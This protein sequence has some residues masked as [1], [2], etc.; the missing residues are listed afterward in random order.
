MR[1]LDRDRRSVFIARYVERAAVKTESGKLT[2]RYEAI[3]SDPV[4]FFP[5]VSATRGEAEYDIFGTALDYDRSLTI[6]DPMFEVGESD[7]LWLDK[8]PDENTPFDHRVSAIAHGG[9][10]TVVAVK[11]VEVSK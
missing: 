9:T 6:D 2:G 7:V 3:Y 10:Y 4:E 8:T 1:C 5:T 11:R